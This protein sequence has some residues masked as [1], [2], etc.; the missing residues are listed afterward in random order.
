MKSNFIKKMKYLTA[1]GMTVFSLWCIFSFCNA[2]N[3]EEKYEKYI[4]T[5]F[6]NSKAI[7]VGLA[8]DAVT[9]I[10]TTKGI[11][12][13]DAGISVSLTA[14]YRKIIESKFGRKNFSY[15]INTH[16]HSD[17]TGGNKVFSDATIIGHKNCLPEMTAYWKNTEKIKSGL[18]KTVRDYEKKL[19]TLDPNSIDREEYFCQM[20]RYQC[21][22]SDL[23]SGHIF[24]PPTV[25]FEDTMNIV[26]GDVT[27]SLCYFGKA[28][29]ESDIMIHIPEMK[30]LMVGDLFSGYGRPNFSDSSKPDVERWINALKWIEARLTNIELVVGGHGK[31]MTKEDLLLFNSFVKKKCS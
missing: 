28:H 16:S 23:T 14:K 10:S 15:L 13:I 6:L 12:V 5:E 3:I 17:H 30:I 20:S 22:Y 21:A 24:T 26:S 25:T 31:I 29:S 11:V 9:A 1:T 19:D 7:I 27:L 8:S 18:S 4:K 2:G